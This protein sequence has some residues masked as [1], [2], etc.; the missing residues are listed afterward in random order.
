MAKIA[1]FNVNSLRAH[2]SHILAWLAE[3]GPDVALLQ[4][5]KCLDEDIPR[6][7]FGSLGYR[8][9]ARG[10]KSYNGVAIL[11]RSECRVTATDL[12]GDAGDAQARYIEADIDVRVGRSA[13]PLRVASIYLP[14]GN[15]AG[16]EKYAYK[17][18]WMDRLRRRAESL[19]RLEAP[20]ALGGDFNVA[21]FDDDVYDPERWAEDALCLPQSRAAFRSILNLGFLDAYRFSHPEGHRYTFW[22]YQAGAWARDE[23]LRIDHLLLSPQ[24]ADA[25]E[26]CE[27]DR[28]PRSKDKPSDHTPIWCKLR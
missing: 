6:L 13:A 20:V 9:A 17:L 12:P 3:E 8:I 25:L 15:P 10:Q 14:N 7:E 24:A 18:A 5:I 16:S 2:L 19:L 4:E 1:A 22:D 26:G 21:P 28:K 27:I 23:G 11:S